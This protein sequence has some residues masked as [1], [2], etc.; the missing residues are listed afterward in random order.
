MDF[1]TCLNDSIDARPS[2][3]TVNDARDHSENGLERAEEA[4]DR[5]DDRRDERRDLRDDR[6]DRRE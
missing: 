4:H 3:S 1:W 2:G 5:R 6:S